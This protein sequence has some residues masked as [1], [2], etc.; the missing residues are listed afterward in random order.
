MKKLF[1]AMACFIGLMFFASCTQ[2]QINE[3]MEQRPVVEFVAGEGFISNNTSAFVEE[4][5]NFK[6]KVAPNSGS[7]SELVSL[8][9]NVATI[10]GADLVNE[11]I[12]ITE[13]TGE[14]VFTRTVTPTEANT[15]V[16]TVTVTDAAG[17]TNAAAVSVNYVEPTVAEIGVFEGVMVIAGHVTSDSIS[18]QHIDQD[19]DTLF[20]PTTITLGALEEGNRVVATFVIDGTPVTLY[21]T[22]EGNHITFDQFNFNRTVNLMIVDF[23][24]NIVMN[25]QADIVDDTMTLTG[26]VTG[27]GTPTILFVQ[28]HAN[29]TGSVEGT[30]AKT[31]K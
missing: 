27:T 5:L 30:F 28:L 31:A 4:E 1:F 18:N 22:M 12:V 19:L 23:V 24:L 6:F 21:S 7:Q 26:N 15:Y 9:F 25:A 16:V 10:N 17:K 20:L 14:N 8:T 2:E 13:P 3:I 29:M 11:N